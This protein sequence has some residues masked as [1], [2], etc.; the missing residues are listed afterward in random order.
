MSRIELKYVKAYTD[1]HGVRRHYFRRPGFQS[2]A[3]PG[4]PGSREFMEAY[5]EAMAGITAPRREI[6]AEKTKPGS[7]S[8]LIVSYYQSSDFLELADETKRTYRNEIERF[9]SAYGDW[10]VISMERRHVLKLL[11]G[12][13]PGSQKARRRILGVLIRHAVE[14]SWRRDN[15]MLGLRRMSRKTEGYKIWSEDDIKAFCAHWPLGTREHIA[16]CLLLYTAQRRS[17]VVKMGRQH[18][19]DGK[20][21]VVQ[22]KT[23]TRLWI[24]MHARLVE[25]LATAPKDQMTFLVAKGDKPFTPPGFYNWFAASAKAAGLHGLSPHGL[26]KSAAVRLAEA[27]CTPHQI[28]SIT[29]HRSLSEVELYTRA[30]EQQRLA[31][32]AMEAISGTGTV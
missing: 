5:G 3:L 18:V 2:V 9:R 7:I 1:R 24:P 17:D 20:I 4:L 8:A 27:N 15:P 12:L 32:Q 19:K 14:R 31:E 11:D 6:G 25:A 10:P 16:L 13:T 28:A 30:V 26:R 29:G 21:S 22:Q 23:G